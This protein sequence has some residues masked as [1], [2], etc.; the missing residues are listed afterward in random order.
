MRRTLNFALSLTLLFFPYETNSVQRSRSPEG[1]RASD[2]RGDNL[3]DERLDEVVQPQM[4]IED[5]VP[6]PPTLP[7]SPI[8]RPRA[9]LPTSTMILQ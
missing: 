7:C 1:S 3:G 8:S 4:E 5:D 9:F 6:S 2:E